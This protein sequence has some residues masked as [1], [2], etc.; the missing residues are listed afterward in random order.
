MTEAEM[1]EIEFFF[2]Y[3]RQKIAISEAKIS[4]LDIKQQQKEGEN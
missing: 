4:F 3:I 1:R 2:E